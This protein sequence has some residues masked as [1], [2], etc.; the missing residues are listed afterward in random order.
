[1][2]GS[3]FI[4]EADN[5]D[6]CVPGLALHSVGY[7][8][9]NRVWEI[10]KA[11][12]YYTSGVVCRISHYDHRLMTNVMS[13][14][15]PRSCQFFP[16]IL[17]RLSML[18]HE[19]SSLKVFCTIWGRSAVVGSFANACQNLRSFVYPLVNETSGKDQENILSEDFSPLARVS[20]TKVRGCR[21]QAWWSLGSSH[22]R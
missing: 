20:H 4:F 17:P 9:D 10:V 11:D 16:T 5:I 22:G 21:S 2:I 14:G 19:L 3:V 1:M 13:S 8:N 18:Y 7:W 12:I 15:I 6:Q